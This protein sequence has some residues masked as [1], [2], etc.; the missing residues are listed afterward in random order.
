MNINCNLPEVTGDHILTDV[1][2]YSSVHIVTETEEDKQSLIADLE[3]NNYNIV[4]ISGSD[5]HW[6]DVYF[7]DIDQ[8]KELRYLLVTYYEVQPLQNA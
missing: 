1:H 4:G 2:P 3:K 7:T 6:V 5:E 8:Y